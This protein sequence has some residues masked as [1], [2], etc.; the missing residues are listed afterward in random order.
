[1]SKFF[2]LV[3]FLIGRKKYVRLEKQQLANF[4]KNEILQRAL[5]RKIK[6]HQRIDKCYRFLG[7]LY[8]VQTAQHERS[9]VQLRKMADELDSRRAQINFLDFKIM[10]MQAD[11]ERQKSL[12]TQIT[13]Q[14]E[15]EKC[16]T[17]MALEYNNCLKLDA[18]N[19]LA[20][21]EHLEQHEA[22][23]PSDEFRLQRPHRLIQAHLYGD[24]VTQKGDEETED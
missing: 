4:K 17:E 3:R 10:R 22:D 7:R 16:K 6:H 8:Q 20:Y 2:W 18:S 15:V 1:M 14:V 21:I 5:G 23:P 13:T 24:E 9:K 12:I 11:N 19:S